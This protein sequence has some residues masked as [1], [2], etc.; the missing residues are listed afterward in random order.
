MSTQSR[1]SRLPWVRL[2]EAGII[3]MN[4]RN[5]RYI[6]LNNPR[7]LYPLVDD[8][9]LTKALALKANIA[10]PAL[11]HEVS[12]E[13]EIGELK[14][15][16]HEHESFVVKPAKGSGGDGIVVIVGRQGDQFI[17]ASGARMSFSD[18]AHHMSNILSGA[19][20][21]GGLPDRA[22]IEYCVKFDPVFAAI[23]F[24]GVPDIRTLVY[25]GIPVAAMLRL[26]TRAS[27]GKANLHQGAVG[28]GVDLHTGRTMNGVMNSMPV[29]HHPDTLHFLKDFQVPQWEQV[30]LLAAQCYELAPLGYLGVD[31]VMDRE[32][33]PLVLELNARPGLAI[34][35]AN[36]RG[37]RPELEKINAICNGGGELPK[38]AQQRVALGLSLRERRQNAETDA[39]PSKTIA[40]NPIQASEPVLSTG[41]SEAALTPSAS[42]SSSV[43]A[44]PEPASL[45]PELTTEP[46]IPAPK[47][48]SSESAPVAPPPAGKI[49]EAP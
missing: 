39:A 20:S 37:L 43:C 24:Q 45:D 32:L 30:L 21:L 41:P 9:L 5:G 34:Q 29:S 31:V 48:A 23:S 35:L 36:G 17:R 26:P 42:A 14:D 6:A 19:F 47:P 38:N 11:Y 46:T 1:W 44:E 12:I 4:E 8:K 7:R 25:R 16:L 27:D 10:V 40:E 2:R 33:G 3:G 13:H 49:D 28:V 18:L 15:T 22:M